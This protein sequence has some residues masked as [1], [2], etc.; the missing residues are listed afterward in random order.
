M[1]QLAAKCTLEQVDFPI[2]Q[3]L[4]KKL[5]FTLLKYQTKTSIN[6]FIKNR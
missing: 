5:M 1:Q 6:V 2:I 4:E 3:A